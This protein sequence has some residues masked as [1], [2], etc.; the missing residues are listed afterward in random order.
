MDPLWEVDDQFARL[1]ELTSHEED[2]K[3]LPLRRD[4][5][6]LGM[7]LGEV[8]KE[9]V[10]LELFSAVEELRQL[11][12]EQREMSQNRN[13][14]AS[15]PHLSK[16]VLPMDPTLPRNGSDL[17]DRA[18]QIVS[19]LSIE[20][21]HQMT[22]SF[23]I[24]FELTNLAETN[25]RKRRRRA[26]QSS[27]E[28]IAQPG[29]F[30]GTL[31]RMRAAD[32][33]VEAARAW[34]S[35][36]EVTLVF[37][38]HPTEVA[39]R[40][41]LFKRQS[42]ARQLEELDRLPLSKRD[43]AKHE[44]AIITE[45][46]SLWQTDE[47]R[48]RRPTVKDEI[49]MGL[50][51][52]PTVLFDTLPKFYEGLAL[53]FREAY[54]GNLTARDLPTLL[55]F[56]SWIGG[57][58]DGNPSVT[59]ECTRDA[60]KISSQLILDYYLERLDDLIWRLT[61]STLQVG[62][63]PGVTAALQHYVETI[64]APDL[65]PDRHAPNEIYRRFLDFVL[66]RLA[67]TRQNSNMS[68]A[69]S[70]AK[71][72]ENDLSLIRDSLR[73]HN[74]ERI[75]RSL[76]D[77]LISQVQTFGFHLHTLDIREH[78]L[79]H[80]RAFDEL[81]EVSQ[82]AEAEKDGFRLPQ[83]VSD[84]TKCLL[85]SMRMIKDLKQTFPPEAIRNYVIS[86]ARSPADV[87]ALLWLAQLAGVQVEASDK[88]NDPGL[89]PVPLFE[90]IEDLRNC[91]E[92]CRALW[93]N[94]D[95]ARLLDSWGRSQEVMLGYSDSNK[96]GGMLTSTW[97]IFKAHR[98]LHE[99]ARECNVE[100]RLF[101]GRGGTVGRGGGPTHHA[102][103][104]Q[105]A[106]AFTGR[107]RITEQ[108]E[109]M[110]WKYSDS[111]LAER[112]LELVI[113]ASLEA[114]SRPRG[115]YRLDQQAET[116]IEAISAD[117]FAYYR[118]NIAENEDVLNYFE[119]ATPVNEP[120]YARIGSRPARRSERTGLDELRAIPW[121]FGWMQSRHVLPA[122]FGVGYALERFA[123]SGVENRKLLQT[124]IDEFPLFHD[125]ID[126]VELGMAKADLSIARQYATLVLDSSMRER[127]FRLIT[128]E[129]A[130]TG[131]IVLELTGQSML[132]EKNPVLARSIRLRNPY[133]DPLSL[134]QID[135]L[136]R[137]RAGEESDELN[138]ALAAT[139]NGIAAGLRNT[140]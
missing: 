97:E 10:G 131:E 116:A 89:M 44:Q 29:S 45:I 11:L 5:R 58:R 26:A 130:R 69:Y 76:I 52:Y 88:R 60:L 78:A 71:E 42:I 92:I 64:S 67:A 9:Q 34:L 104:A 112:N 105:P 135:L 50:D 79:V 17:M 132:L 39:R 120:E 94:R 72:F 81:S 103:I 57:D 95:Y 118:Q 21:A 70:N 22:K 66:A 31:R 62:V 75:A 54:G 27:A 91:P 48:R 101:H 113:A 100:L 6:S 124:L 119:E 19:R 77:P 13:A 25:H 3:E 115:A 47:V 121:V 111:I 15:G 24:Y 136:R 83:P 127:V 23:A 73:E 33:T 139:I 7:L 59:P 56:G 74:G 80:R 107:I 53:D 49:R 98:T 38:A 20:Q 122:W 140:G 18:K 2:L 96:D 4:V 133:V 16:T 134:I 51:Y 128:E 102:I 106:G 28:L 30:L 138:Y 114:L 37:T 41:V 12:I 90:S 110:N 129:F 46:T 123:H 32:I 87:A 82:N 86:G 1:A 40:T 43:A 68:I 126:N 8:L 61:P 109:V 99:V 35:Q 65:N 125:L 36:I 93:T 63:S 137:K 55:F 108:G 117:A 14:V 84:E 85:D